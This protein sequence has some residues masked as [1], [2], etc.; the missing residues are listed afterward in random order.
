M[1][2]QIN[3]M[4]TTIDT[5]DSLTVFQLDC[6]IHKTACAIRQNYARNIDDSALR[7]RFFDLVFKWEKSTGLSWGS[8]SNQL[9]FEKAMLVNFY[10]SRDDLRPWLASHI[11]GE[12]VGELIHGHFRD[13]TSW[14]R[15]AL[16]VTS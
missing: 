10:Q 13:Q 8:L 1:L 7:S 9:Y 3:D 4:T 2:Q 14:F 16:T 15:S 6:R 11:R 12:M 5:T